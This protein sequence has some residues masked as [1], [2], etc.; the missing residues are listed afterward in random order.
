MNYGT[1]I[2]IVFIRNLYVCVSGG[3]HSATVNSIVYLRDIRRGYAALSRLL[4]Y[5][6]LI[7]PSL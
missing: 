5:S 1:L 3:L 4:G 7:K 2:I 6:V